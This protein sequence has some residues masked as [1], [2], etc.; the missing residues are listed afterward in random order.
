MS[1]LCEITNDSYA[2]YAMICEL[3]THFY[4]SGCCNQG[5]KPCIALLKCDFDLTLKCG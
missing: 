4:S 5:I 3:V 2:F 1:Y